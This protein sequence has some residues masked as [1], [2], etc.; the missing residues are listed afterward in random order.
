MPIV[1]LG[2]FRP[3]SPAIKASAAPDLADA[4]GCVPTV[5][6]YAPLPG[7]TAVTNALADKCIGAISARDITQGAHVYAGDGTALYALAGTT[8]SDISKVGGYGPVSQ[9][10][11]W[12]FATY[13]DRLI[14]VN[15]WYD[16]AQ[17]ID[18]SSGSAFDDLPGS[19]GKA[20]FVAQYSEFVFLAALSTNGM[21]LKWSG[22]GDSEEWTPGT[23]QSDEQEIPDG[24]RITGMVG[25]STLLLFQERA[26]RR[27]LYTGGAT[28]MDIQKVSD[29]VGCVEPGSLVHFGRLAFFLSEDGWYM[30]DLETFEL[31][32]IGVNL[33]DL[34]FQAD[35]NRSYWYAMCGALDPRKKIVAWA[36]A[37]QG[38]GA[39][40]PDTIL[41]YNWVARK[42]T[43]AR[44][45]TEFLMNALTTGLSRDDVAFA[46]LSADDAAFAS[47][48]SDDPFF[49]GGS[50]YMAAFDTAHKLASFAGD[51]VEAT[52]QTNPFPL[53]DQQRARV[54]WLKPI[55]DTTGA[56]MA[57]GAQVRAGDAIV[58]QAAQA[59]QTSGRCPQRGVNGFFCAARMTIPSGEDWTYAS[60]L[61]FLAHPAGVR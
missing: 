24:G 29:T 52:L 11:R 5:E 28:I 31:Q 32:P 12:R 25:A 19:P 51:N 36:Y 57:G 26:I 6:A 1:P 49:F 9:S 53:L 35:S 47:L 3:D 2:V 39:G 30:M 41:F 43:Y 8:W 20:Q 18:M 21:L 27:V 37:S 46:S 38:S 17:Y 61:D 56:T 22:F 13:G 14:A 54:E 58:F 33:F 45:D 4:Q 48:S 42:P 34:W 15:G 59:Q 60:A 7:L 23:D 10:S 50:F 55:A 16:D 40:L 44:I